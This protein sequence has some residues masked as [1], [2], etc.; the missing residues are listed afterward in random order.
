MGPEALF[1]WMM[2]VALAWV[3]LVIGASVV[4]RRRRGKPIF[5]RVPDDAV[6]V[7]R[8]ASARW[9]SN[10]LVVAVTREAL[11]VFPPFPFNLMFLPEVY[12]FERTIPLRE[13]TDVRAVRRLSGLNISV[14]YGA[15]REFSLKVRDPAAL[16]AAMRAGRG[17]G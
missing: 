3:A 13:V 4:V 9:A 16:M 8:R 1:L 12:G 15:G 5:T 6:Y 10:A 2:P 11:I 14:E 17:V 7:E